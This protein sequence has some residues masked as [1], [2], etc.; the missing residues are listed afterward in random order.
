MRCRLIAFL[1]AVVFAGIMAA[2]ARSTRRATANPS[3][4]AR[5][6]PSEDTAAGSVAR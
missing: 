3:A 5:V 2:P 1:C 6:L 4:G